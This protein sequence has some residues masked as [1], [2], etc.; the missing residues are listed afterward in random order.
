M[1][2]SKNI[3]IKIKQEKRNREIFT[4]GTPDAACT[5]QQPTQL[6]PF[7]TARGLDTQR[8]LWNRHLN[9]TAL[10]HRQS[11]GDNTTW[12]QELLHRTSEN[13][14]CCQPLIKGSKLPAKKNCRTRGWRC[15]WKYGR[16]WIP[17]A[18]GAEE[19][20]PWNCSS[21]NTSP[22]RRADF[23]SVMFPLQIKPI[24]KDHSFPIISLSCSH[25]TINSKLRLV[26]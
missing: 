22:K 15:M 19:R 20:P 7:T 5:S 26:K 14:K 6:S 16:K 13:S 9:F 24:S 8:E 25:H 21:R 17:R 10:T 23:L 18:L 4:P 11:T 3:R 1:T 2:Q 12:E